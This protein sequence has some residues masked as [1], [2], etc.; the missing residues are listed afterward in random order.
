MT[1]S[2]T[3][4]PKGILSW[5][6]RRVLPKVSKLC[7]LLG[8]MI[9]GA[10]II[11]R[12]LTDQYRWSQYLWWVP[13]LWALGSAWG[14]LIVS[15]L[16]ALFARRLGGIFLRP[17]LLLA[18]IGTTGY[19]F[20]GIWHM[21][22][23]LLPARIPD[24]A[25]R[26]VHW[27]QSSKKVDQA[28]FAKFVLDQEVDIVLVS[29]S[30][31]SKDKQALL[32][33]LAPLAPDEQRRWVNYSYK[34]FVDPAHFRIEGDV[35]IASKY[36][37]VRTGMVKVNTPTKQESPVRPGSSHGWVLF[38]EFDRRDA[39]KSP[40]DQPEP[41]IVWFV[42]LPSNPIAW[43]RRMMQSVSNAVRAWDG[44][45]SVMGRHI[46]ETIETDD[47]FPSPDLIIGDFNTLRGSA[48]LDR[49]APDMTDAFEAT[50]Y[51]R[52]RS[53]MPL[54]QN[55]YLRQLFKLAD[56]H[57]DLAL[58]GDRW[59]P[60]GYQIRNT[61]QWGWTEHRMQIVDITEKTLK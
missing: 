7:A 20:F 41:F 56:W 16:F 22:R 9:L 59:K 12:V 38:A 34:G 48:S 36:P 32:D 44:T 57:I 54:T 31:W 25:I 28:G 61:R 42:D 49:I 26:I 19:L 21:H 18:C 5:T 6:R 24:D 35:F 52:G 55:K 15:A 53:W 27:N 40:G 39:G 4:P 13:P 58:V 2:R 37:L 45:S 23:A 33:H 47:P 29:N 3:S 17:V 60:A 46:W 1:Q 51:G 50:G 14:A 10:W 43:R 8:L 30:T 11:G